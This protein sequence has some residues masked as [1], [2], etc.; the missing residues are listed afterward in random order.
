MTDRDI[1]LGET[2][3]LNGHPLS[4]HDGRTFMGN[5]DEG[6]R[7]ALNRGA[8]NRDVR[9]F[10]CEGIT[11]INLKV[12]VGGVIKNAASSNSRSRSVFQ[13]TGTVIVRRLSGGFGATRRAYWSSSH[14]CTPYG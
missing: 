5:S 14:Y 3:L 11:P 8:S 10:I 12:T 7:G 1:P 13:N 2:F 9:Q 6:R 4:L